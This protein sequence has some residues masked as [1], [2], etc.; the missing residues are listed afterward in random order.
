LRINKCVY[1]WLAMFA[2]AGCQTQQSKP[3]DPQQLAALPAVNMFAG[4]SGESTDWEQLFVAMDAADIIV[5]GE[6]H[7]DAAGHAIQIELIKVAVQRW[8]GMALSVEEFDRSQQA[9]LDAY[10]RGDMTAAELKDTRAFVNP[11]FKANWE[12]WFLPML[13]TA[14]AAD[15]PVVASNAPLKYSRLVRNYGCDDLPE[16]TADERALFVCPSVPVDPAYRARFA[17]AFKGIAKRNPTTGLKELQDEQIDKLFR[18]HCVWDATMADS[19]VRARRQ[20]AAKVVHSV[21]GFHTQF[22]GGLM[23]EIRARD[24]T[25]RILLISLIPKRGDQLYKSDA[26]KADVVI[27]TRS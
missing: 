8:E 13:T 18:A 22:N 20:G 19:I 6:S 25:A 10:S 7:T 11:M 16:L 23:Q 14:R 24:A 3:V 27:Y 5:I 9:Y 4:D 26:D 15:V 21:G 17:K 1:A 2:V 12:E